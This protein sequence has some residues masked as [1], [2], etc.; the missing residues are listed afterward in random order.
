MAHLHK[1]SVSFIVLSSV[2]VCGGTHQAVAQ[3]QPQSA[4]QTADQLSCEKDF[5]DVAISSCSRAIKANSKDAVA[6]KN[7]AFEWREKGDL[8]KAIADYNEAIRISPQY[9]KAYYNR[10]VAWGRKG[11]YEKAIL[12]YS[13]AIRLSPHLPNAYAGR[14]NIYLKKK[15]PYGAI[16]DLSRAIELKPDQKLFFIQRCRAFVDAELPQKAISDCNE[17]IKMDTKFAMSYYNRGNVWLA[18]EQFSQAI[19]DF[20]VA[21]E[22]EPTEYPDYYL[23]RAT[24]YEGNA[25]LGKAVFDIEKYLDLK[26]QDQKAA[27]TK[28][29]LLIALQKKQLDD[30]DVSRRAAEK[31][32]QEKAEFLKEKN[33][34][35]EIASQQQLIKA[36]TER[37][38]DEDKLAF[39]IGSIIGLVIVIAVVL[40]VMLYRRRNQTR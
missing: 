26:P 4:V 32:L 27:E 28:S 6:Y 23:Q 15:D 16:S 14:G 38:I 31:A 25:E 30:E 37:K 24:A 34:A 33:K 9:D 36:A 2:L 1:R 40:G 5:G 20:S 8:E 29:R 17:A 13:E 19:N 22:S 7:R 18:M 11:E 21:L 12:D 35:E 10:G 3:K 39:L